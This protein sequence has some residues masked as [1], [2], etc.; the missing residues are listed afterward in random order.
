MPNQNI[1]ENGGFESGSLVPWVSSFA[2]IT[3]QF[4]HSGNFAAELDGG[5][6][7]AY[8]AQYAIPAIP[9]NSYSLSLYLAKDS[10]LAAPPVQ[11]QIIFLNEAFQTT[12]TGLFQAVSA[13]NIPYAGQGNW[14]TIT[15]TTEIAPPGTTQIYLLINTLPAPAA[16]DVLVDDVS[17]VAEGGIPT[18]PTGPTGIT[19]AT[20]PTGA[21]GI[22]GVTGATGS[23]GLTGV[24]GETGSTGI[25]GVTGETGVT[26]ITGVTG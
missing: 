23:T 7:V 10:E 13:E 11:I 14:A 5:Q 8:L 12:G 22:T 4:V 2:S 3:Q 18:G 17:V 20:G 1:V 6:N 21:T 24:T 16:A 9:G 26:G 25:T 19:G 15:A